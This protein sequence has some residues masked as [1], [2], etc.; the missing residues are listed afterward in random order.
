MFLKVFW[1]KYAQR[2]SSF[3]SVL[4]LFLIA[5]YRSFLSGTLGSGGSCRFYPS[6]SEY[7]FLAYKN[8]P[9]FKATRLVCKRL[10]DCR[11]FGPKL[12]EEPCFIDLKPLENGEKPKGI[13]TD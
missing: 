7:A 2:L 9:F 12:R 11:P 5:F 4:A 8:L 13:I 6:C 3:A 1:R 10:L